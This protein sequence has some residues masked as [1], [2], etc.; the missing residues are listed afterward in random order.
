MFIALSACSPSPDDQ[1]KQLN[2]AGKQLYQ[3]SNYHDAIQKWQQAVEIPVSKPPILYLFMA[4]AWLRLAE[5]DKANDIIKQAQTIFP[6]NTDLNTEA[7]RIQLISSP[8]V[9]AE[10][11]LPPLKTAALPEEQILQGDILVIKGNLARAESAYNLAVASKSSSKALIRLALC[12]LGRHDNKGAAEAYSKLTSVMPQNPDILNQIGMYWSLKGNRQKAEFYML[13]AI[14]FDPGNLLFKKSLAE[15]YFVNNQQEKA[16]STIREALKIAPASRLLNNFLIE[17]L[18]GQN[19]LSQAAAMLKSQAVDGSKDVIFHLLQGKY[20]LL[21]KQP[22]LA[23]SQFSEAIKNE[24]KLPISHYLLALTYLADHRP[25]LAEQSAIEALTL[26]HYFSEAELLLADIYYNNK[27][28]P[29]ALEHVNRILTREPENFRPQLLKGVIL[30]AKGQ[31][32]KANNNFTKASILNPS[33]TG[34]R[35]FSAR[36]IE[37]DG[38]A[39]KAAEMYRQIL[40]NNPNMLPAL[41][42]YIALLSREDKQGEQINAFINSLPA[43]AKNSPEFQNMLGRIYLKGQK[44][45]Q[46]LKYFKK[47]IQLD[48]HQAAAYMGVAEIFALDHNWPEFVKILEDCITQQPDYIPAILKLAKFYYSPPPLEDNDPAR[49]TKAQTLLEK[50]LKRVPDSPRLANSL[51]WLLLR[52]N[53]D[54]NRA[55]I[56]A[57]KSYEKMPNDPAISD[58]L[59]WAYYKKKMFTRAGW[60]MEEALGNSPQQPIIHIHLGKVLLAKGENSQALQHL[61]TGLALNPPPEY[62]KIAQELINIMQSAK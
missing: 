13:K 46:A 40:Q 25:G 55:F 51:A 17:I 47:A 45:E 11:I 9:L 2:K 36:A 60:I 26:N 52:N 62:K 20:F 22:Y 61:K 33:L 24:P 50:G 8:A 1:L 38:K 28:F 6:A 44:K 19:K 35:Y 41:Q 34:S 4:E 54:I 7:A 43:N 27:Q 10:K 32:S 48:S 59:A 23:V 53:E 31:Y 29:L 21:N 58:T 3:A 16:A 49:M 12:R 57:R 56:L 42:R 14:N 37:L 30:L 18:L 15:F 5:P 39:P